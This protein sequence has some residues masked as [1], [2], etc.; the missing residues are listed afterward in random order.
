MDFSWKIC[1]RD[2]IDVKGFQV[3]VLNTFKD[4]R[5]LEKVFDNPNFVKAFPFHDD[6]HFK[7]FCRVS[8]LD[9][10]QWVLSKSWRELYKYVKPMPIGLM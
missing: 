10:C 4:E 7:A 6:G 3:P 5:K 2:Q 8:T 9:K 1:K